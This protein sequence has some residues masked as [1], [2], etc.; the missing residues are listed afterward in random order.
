[1][2]KEDCLRDTPFTRKTKVH[3]FGRGTDRH[4]WGKRP[5]L[6]MRKLIFLDV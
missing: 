4:L 2:R 6:S 3:P 1:L 5:Y